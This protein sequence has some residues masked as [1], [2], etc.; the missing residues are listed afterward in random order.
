MDTLNLVDDQFCFACGKNNPTGLGLVFEYPEPG[1]CRA[2]FVPSA[3]FQGWRGV[4]HGGIISTL[5]DE[6][7]AHALGGSDRGGGGSGAVTAELVVRFKKPVPI[8][9]KVVLTGR[10]V[11]TKGRVAEAESE[12]TDGQGTVLASAAGKLVRPRNNCHP[13]GSPRLAG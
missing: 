1:R 9:A 2:E 5:L 12:I 7:L 11:S 13:E 4:L 8:G 3:K 10:V 6:A